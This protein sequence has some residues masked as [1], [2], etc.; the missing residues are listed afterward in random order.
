MAER[1]MFAKTIIDSDAFLDMPQSAQLLY[2]H[3][4]MRADDDGFINN[5]KSIIR[6]IKCS[7]DDFQMLSSKKFII[8]F[9]SGVVV[10]KHW[11]INNYIAKDRYRETKYKNELS[12][13]ELDENNS[14]RHMDTTC[15]QPVYK[16]ET[17]VR[18]GKDSIGKVSIG[19]RGGGSSLFTPPTEKEVEEFCRE[20][21]YRVDAARFVSYYI[22]NGW[23]VGINPMKDWRAS[24]RAWTRSGTERE[25]PAHET[26]D[27]TFDTDEF[28]RIALEHSYAAIDHSADKVDGNDSGVADKTDKPDSI[29]GG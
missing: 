24:V 3:L 23:K 16:M 25:R 6:N 28:F 9:E 2:F 12:M 26:T 20:N 5:P 14:Y 4:S 18:S 7:E 15:I 29:Q 22:S 1:R 10:I 17:Q 21:G 11:K 19:E 27:S 8:L 13:L